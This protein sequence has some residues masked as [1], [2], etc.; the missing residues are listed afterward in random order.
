MALFSDGRLVT[1][2]FTAS[3]TSHSLK[4]EY[5]SQLRSALLPHGLLPKEKVLHW[6]IVKDD[7]VLEKFKHKTPS[8]TGS[9][10]CRLEFTV[11]VCK[12]T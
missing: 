11:S 8:G 1:L 5:V 3:A 12:S 4:L 6:F 7:D 2:Q 9:P 10:S